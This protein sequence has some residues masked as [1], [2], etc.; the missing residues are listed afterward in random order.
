MSIPFHWCNHINIVQLQSAICWYF[1]GS[2]LFYFQQKLRT[3]KDKEFSFFIVSSLNSEGSYKMMLL[4]L[5]VYLPVLCP[6]DGESESKGEPMGG[7]LILVHSSSRG[8]LLLWTREV[9]KSSSQCVGNSKWRHSTACR[10]T[11]PHIIKREIFI[12]LFFYFFTFLP[13]LLLDGIVV[14][15]GL[16]YT[17]FGYLSGIDL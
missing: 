14:A 11:D 7:F 3:E 12:S 16:Y 15:R 9:E 1:L 6:R 5:S 10:P 4:L 2:L 13:F 17:T 8:K